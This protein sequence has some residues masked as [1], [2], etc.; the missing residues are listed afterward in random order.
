MLY[1]VITRYTDVQEIGPPVHEKS[2]EIAM[3]PAIEKN[4]Y[5]FSS[6]RDGGNGGWDIYYTYFIDGKFSK[7]VILGK[8]INTEHDELY[9]VPTLKYSLLASNRPDS[10]YNFV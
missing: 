9:Y 2:L 7:P 5:Y 3:I 10:S 6:I 8:E 4:K 1:E